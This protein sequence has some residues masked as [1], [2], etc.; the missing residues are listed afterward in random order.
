MAKDATAFYSMTTKLEEI[1]KN[2]ESVNTVTYGDLFEVALDKQTL[3]PLSHFVVNN[4]RVDSNSYV[5]NISLICMDI[6]D[7]IKEDTTD[8]FN[9]NDNQ[10]DIFNTQLAVVTRAMQ[11]FQRYDLRSEGYELVGQPT[12]ESFTHR[13]EDD[14]CGWVVTFDVRVIQNMEV[15][16]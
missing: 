11:L 9:G 10:M 14:V 3:F 8:K 6:I 12:T 1:L 2:D 13:F 16:G 7:Q 4:V 15:C 5:F